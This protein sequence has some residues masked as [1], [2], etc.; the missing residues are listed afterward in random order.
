MMW[1]KLPSI[2]RSEEGRIFFRVNADA[3]GYDVDENG[4]IIDEEGEVLHE[5]H[6]D[7]AGIME[8]ALEQAMVE[9]NRE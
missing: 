2:L 4:N 8:R 3:Y 9:G 1:Y 5:D 7:Y 6:D